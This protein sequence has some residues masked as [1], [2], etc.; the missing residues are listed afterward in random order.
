VKKK[1]RLGRGLD[2]LLSKSASELFDPITLDSKDSDSL[3]NIPVDLLQRGKYQ[4][5]VDIR[6]DTLQQLA[7][8]IRSQG[9][10][11]PIVVRPIKNSSGSNARY[12]IIAGER[13]W[14]ASQMAGKHEVP[15]IIREI[16][17][18]DAIAIAL[19]EN[20]QRENLNPLEEAKALSRL[21]AEFDITHKQAADVVGRSRVAVSNLLRLL[22]L[23]DEVKPMVEARQLEMG[24]ARALLSLENPSQQLSV[25]RDII[26]RGLSVRATEKLIR[27]LLN[28]E[29]KL[30][31]TKTQRDSN[32]KHLEKDISDKL[33]AKTLIIHTAKGSGKLV[34]KYNTLDEL[35]GILKHIK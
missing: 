17:N 34:I 30:S 10:I 27:G 19:I 14:R 7:E 9:V 2:A 23:S 20:I 24:H 1:K 16:E 13:R 35:D 33:G 28:H 21:I 22:D 25:A 15:A 5:R 32:I 11:Q 18:V 29:L 4:P 8:S 26:K 31:D 3:K 12:E 6:Q